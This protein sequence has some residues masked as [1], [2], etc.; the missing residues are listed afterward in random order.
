M[1][2]ID[3]LKTAIDKDVFLKFSESKDVL[4]VDKDAVG[5]WDLLFGV[6]F[7]IVVVYAHPGAAGSEAGV[8]LFVPLV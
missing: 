4:P 3:H 5:I 1:L 8:F 6:P 7:G 2:V